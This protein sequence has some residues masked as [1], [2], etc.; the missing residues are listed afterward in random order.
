ME[1]KANYDVQ[2]VP[3]LLSQSSARLASH[4]TCGSM[5][6]LQ[7]TVT[8]PVE[9]MLTTNSEQN[10]TARSSV[11][12]SQKSTKIKLNDNSTDEEEEKGGKACLGCLRS[13]YGASGAH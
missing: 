4:K 13:V 1:K 9:K 2:A 6:S 10:L 3:R 8:R 12:N 5:A 11:L 7:L